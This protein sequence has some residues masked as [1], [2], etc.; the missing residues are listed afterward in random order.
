MSNQIIGNA[1]LYYACYSLSLRGWNAI[2]TSRNARG[3]DIVAYDTDC[4]RVV[5]LQVK[6][7]SNVTAVPLGKSIDRLI[8]HFWIIVTSV[9]S[10]RPITYIMRPD[11]VQAGALKRDNPEKRI[12][13]WLPV[14]EYDRPEFREAWPRIGVID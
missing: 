4:K 6:T 2:P 11:E 7:L 10:G 3:V 5:G 9:V 14:R 13:Y 1:G 8:G 12:S